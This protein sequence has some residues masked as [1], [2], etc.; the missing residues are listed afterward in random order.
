MLASG[1]SRGPPAASYPQ[2]GPDSPE[3]GE[4]LSFSHQGGKLFLAGGGGNG[5]NGAEAMRNVLTLKGFT[6]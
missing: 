2:L 5:E 4:I 1:E 6:N 3:R